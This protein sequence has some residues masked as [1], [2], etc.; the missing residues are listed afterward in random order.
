[1]RRFNRK[2]EEERYKN[3]RLPFNGTKNLPKRYDKGTFYVLIITSGRCLR[4]PYR[5]ISDPPMYKTQEQAQKVL[6]AY[7]KFSAK[8]N[9][10]KIANRL[11]EEFEV[12]EFTGKISELS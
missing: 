10:N 7:V 6:E 9:H 4:W 5:S 8:S 2:A 11:A 3:E 1:M 12:V